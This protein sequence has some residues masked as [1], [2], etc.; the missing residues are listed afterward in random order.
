MT[1]APQPSPVLTASA[2]PEPSSPPPPAAA[3]V[4]KAPIEH[5]ANPSKHSTRNAHPPASKAEAQEAPSTGPPGYLSLRV[6]PWGEIW[7]DGQKVAET[8]ALIRH[9][10]PPGTHKLWVKNGPLA[11]EQE[12]PVNIT[13]GATL[14][15]RV[16]FVSP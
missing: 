11:K 16:S 6:D 9:P 5:R 15:K 8:S 12:L 7:V 3:E 4:A 2:P 1:S 14:V 10:L 13:S